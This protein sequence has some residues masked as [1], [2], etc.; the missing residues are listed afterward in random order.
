MICKLPTESKKEEKNESV[1]IDTKMISNKKIFQIVM[2][3][4]LTKKLSKSV[5]K[6]KIFSIELVS[7]FCFYNNG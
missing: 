7:T 1:S 3:N 5:R 4:G 6:A 2:K